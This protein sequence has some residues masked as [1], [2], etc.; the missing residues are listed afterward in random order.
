MKTPINYARS[1][2]AIF[3]GFLVL[4]MIVTLSTA[5]VMKVVAAPPAAVLLAIN[6]IAGLIAGYVTAVLAGAYRWQHSLLL[7][8]IISAIGLLALNS[9]NRPPSDDYSKY[10]LVIS[11]LGIVIGGL[12]RHFKAK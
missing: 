1:V 12:I 2:A 4:M 6:I 10:A 8:T 3:L 5:L 7:A 11:P 9:M